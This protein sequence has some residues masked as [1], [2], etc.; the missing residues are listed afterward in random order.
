MI[1]RRIEGPKISLQLHDIL[2]KGLNDIKDP[3]EKRDRIDFVI[4]ALIVQL[5][6]VLSIFTKE[7]DSTAVVLEIS[8]SLSH[9]LNNRNKFK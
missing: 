8:K 4:D 6:T 7:E 9:N 3:E 1:D 5:S 2:L